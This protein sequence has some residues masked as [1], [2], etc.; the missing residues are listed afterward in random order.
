MEG[1]GDESR[2]LHTPRR[3]PTPIPHMRA[4]TLFLPTSSLICAAAASRS[5]GLN[6]SMGDEKRRGSGARATAA[7]ACTCVDGRK[8]IQMGEIEQARKIEN[9]LTLE[10]SMYPFNRPPTDLLGDASAPDDER[11]REEGL[12]ALQ[13]HGRSRRQRQGQRNGREAQHRWWSCV[14]EHGRSGL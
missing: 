10:T 5:A 14:E 6:S 1:G 12:G 4:S 7:G 2:C 13:E 3:S 9:P 11:G 8:S